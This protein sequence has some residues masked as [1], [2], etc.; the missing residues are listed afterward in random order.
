MQLS[1]TSLILARSLRKYFARHNWQV[2]GFTFLTLVASTLLWGLLYFGSLLLC[3][4]V[5]A[6]IYEGDLPAPKGFPFVF[7][8]IAAALIFSA[9]F[10]HVLAASERPPDRRLVAEIVLDIVLA[11]PR[12]TLAIYGNLSAWQ[13]LSR[14]QLELAA[15]LVERVARERKVPMHATPVDIPN[16]R[17]REKIVFALLLLRILDVQQEENGVARLRI[18][19]F[20]PE[21]LKLPDPAPRRS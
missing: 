21:G 8:A 4:L 16:D 12:T 11:I 5:R 19:P 14:R 17:E 7:G 10:D 9:W 18:S 20:R 13:W 6:L 1:K 15:R 2:L 3:L